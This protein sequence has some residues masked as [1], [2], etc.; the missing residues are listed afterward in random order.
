MLKKFDDWLT[1]ATPEEKI[2]AAKRSLAAIGEL[3]TTHQGRFVDEVR[4]DPTIAKL[5][6]DLKTTV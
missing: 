6:D 2:Y 4:T 5:F 1:D 3:D